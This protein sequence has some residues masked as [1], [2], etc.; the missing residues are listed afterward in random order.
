MLDGYAAALP[1]L[2]A[3]VANMAGM[4]WLALAME[5]HWEQVRG[6]AQPRQAVRRLRWLGVFGLACG[7]ALCL[8][9]DHASMA[10]LVWVMTLAAAA[11]AVALTLSWR[12]RWLTGL[13]WMAGR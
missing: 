13:A 7:L 2:A 9:V 11:L 12:P 3:V 1:L 8:Q 4:A 6:T 10:A 5:V